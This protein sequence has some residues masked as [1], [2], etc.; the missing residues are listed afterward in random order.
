MNNRY[1]IQNDLKWIYSS[2]PFD[3][4]SSGSGQNY[5]TPQT[6]AYQTIYDGSHTADINS[7]Y[8]QSAV[9][10]PAGGS[11][12]TATTTI[13]PVGSGASATV[14]LEL[15]SGA[16]ATATISIP[17]VGNGYVNA[18]NITNGG[19]LYDSPP[20]VV[21]TPVGTP[22]PTIAAT[23][24]TTITSGVVTS[25][26]IT[27]GGT[28]YSTAPTITLTP[29]TGKVTSS[30]TSLVGGSS[31]QTPPT[32]TI[33]DTHADPGTDAD[34]T[35]T[36]TAGAVSGFTVV[37][38]GTGYHSGTT[39][40]VIAAET[41]SLSTPF[42][43]LTA[44]GSGFYSVP[45]VVITDSTSPAGTG[46]SAVATIS[47]GAVTGFTSIANGSGYHPSTTTVTF[48]GGGSPQSSV[49]STVLQILPNESAVSC[50]LYSG[51]GGASYLT[52]A[53]GTTSGRS[54]MVMVLQNVCTATGGSCSSVT[55]SDPP[56]SGEAGCIGLGGTWTHTY[57]FVST[58]YE[59]GC[60]Y[61]R[62]QYILTASGA[63]ITVGSTSGMQSNMAVLYQLLLDLTSAAYGKDYL[64]PVEP[65]TSGYSVGQGDASFKQETED[66]KSTI[67]L[68]IAAHNTERGR[69]AAGILSPSSYLT[70]FTN[71][72]A[73]MLTYKEA[74]KRRITEISNRIG[75]LN[76]KDTASGGST[77]SPA[78]SLG[79]A[80]DGFQG[81]AFSNGNGYANTVYSHANFLAGNKIKLLNKILTA[82]SDVDSIY[83]QITSNRAEYYE[84]NQ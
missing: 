62:I 27:Y 84:Y 9:Q 38:A 47:A 35:T 41:G 40:A 16:A 45:T 46:A 79:A 74:V 37:N 64:D 30:F 18:I 24:E 15:G 28:G 52:Y 5:Q 48:T 63:A 2:D 3:A 61:N 69:V 12:A 43:T 44:G 39:T 80:G 10:G 32:V 50:S 56:P 8:S 77:A 73:E 65:N 17:S 81:Y 70:A 25:I 57:S 49:G 82:I 78:K 23:A 51:P 76:G 6:G 26:T 75:Y 58:T 33:T 66:M 7:V 21:F 20:T 60:L 71:Y 36:L 83:T 72:E 4:K 67:D 29:V 53:L 34:V 14:G 13:A 54:N 68:L 59:F 42:L 31:F 19:T 1:I 22:Y 11:G 55:G